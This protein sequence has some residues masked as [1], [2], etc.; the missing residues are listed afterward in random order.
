MGF[1]CMIKVGVFKEYTYE[2]M[3]DAYQKCSAA[4]LTSNNNL[5]VLMASNSNPLNNPGVYV[6]N[7]ME[8]F[9]S[10]RP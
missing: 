10:Y 1:S 2:K 5:Y 8:S 4:K 7:A 3:D 9:K 6:M